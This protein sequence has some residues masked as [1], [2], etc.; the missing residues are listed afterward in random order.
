[1]LRF[2]HHDN[3]KFFPAKLKIALVVIQVLAV[4]IQYPAH[5]VIFSAAEHD[6]VVLIG[7]DG[8]ECEWFRLLHVNATERRK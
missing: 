4:E 7:D 8:F 3:I 1:M 2:G 5:R 6:G